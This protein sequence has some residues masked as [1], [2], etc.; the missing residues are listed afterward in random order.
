[1]TRSPLQHA[2]FKTSLV[3][4]HP[5]TAGGCLVERV[6]VWLSQA[7][8]IFGLT[9]SVEPRS[10]NSQELTREGRTDLVGG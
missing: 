5:W 8:A 7:D 10:G 3:L 4:M 2:F 1:M 6:H 9:G